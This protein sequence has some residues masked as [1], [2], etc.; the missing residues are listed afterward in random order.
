MTPALRAKTTDAIAFARD[1]LLLAGAAVEREDDVTA[2]EEIGLAVDR[3]REVA[4]E[5]KSDRTRSQV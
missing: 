4:G 2:A 1:R 5:L 3:L